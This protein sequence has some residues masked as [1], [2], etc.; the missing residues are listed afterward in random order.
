MLV[1]GVQTLAHLRHWMQPETRRTPLFEQPGNSK[2]IREPLGTVL[3][4]GKLL[5]AS[6][7]GGAATQ[8]CFRLPPN[9]SRTAG[10]PAF[11]WRTHSRL[12]GA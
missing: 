8:I 9:L 2:I 4:I 12:P 11:G 5:R 1:R 3:V 6:N 7:P 10:P